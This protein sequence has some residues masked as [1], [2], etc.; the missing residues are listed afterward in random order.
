MLRHSLLALGMGVLLWSLGWGRQA[1]PSVF[2]PTGTVTGHVIFAET[3][4]AARLVEVTLARRPTADEVKA[5]ASE[6]GADKV[7]PRTVAISGRTGLDGSFLISGVSAG[8]YYVVAKLEGYVLPIGPITSEKQAVDVDTVMRDIP[9]VSVAG[10]E[11][12][13]V[14]VS[15]HHGG[16]ISGRVQ[17]K[18]GAPVVEAFISVEPLEAEER[19]LSVRPF[20]LEQA[21]RME[22]DRVLTDDEG[23]FRVVGL[24]PA[25]T[26]FRPR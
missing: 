20:Y 12:A 2:T 17:F 21:L 18:D 3:R 22:S 26:R 5:D 19:D 11:T 7:P 14:N 24:R 9:L 1:T 8:E 4:Q 16:V 6:Q 13:E 25:S 15:L 10:N 23:R